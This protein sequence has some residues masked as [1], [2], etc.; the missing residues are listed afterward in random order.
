MRNS[1]HVGILLLLLCSCVAQKPAGLSVNER[2]ARA[3]AKL[4]LWDK[5][6]EQLPGT[7]LSGLIQ[8]WGE[9]EKLKN[10]EY[11]WLR[12]ESYRG[13]GYYEPDGHTSSKVYR[14]TATGISEHV[15]YIDTPKERYVEPYTFE[16]R[17]EIRVTTNK[18]GIITHVRYDGPGTG[19]NHALYRDELFPLP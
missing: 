2:I 11:R 6:F 9:P 10:N 4:M 1:I 16:K 14:T 19:G 15:G 8:A 17:C 7:H 5:K 12:D 3:E 13:G 18:N